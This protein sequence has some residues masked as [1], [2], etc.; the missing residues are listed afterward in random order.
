MVLWFPGLPE[1]APDF[2]NACPGRLLFLSN[3]M[4]VSNVSMAIFGSRKSYFV[5]EGGELY[6]LTTEAVVLK[7]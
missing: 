7:I 5:R 4:T 2:Y 1:A 6:P 3:I